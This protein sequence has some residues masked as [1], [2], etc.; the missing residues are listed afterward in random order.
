M[1][2]ALALTAF[3]RPQYLQQVLESLRRTGASDYTMFIGVEPVSSEVIKVCRSIDFLPTEITIN[4]KI[5]GVRENPF[6]TI[7]RAF[8]AGYDAVWQL[9]DDVVLSPDAANLVGA[10]LEFDR[11]DDFLCLNLYNSDSKVD[12]EH[13]IIASKGFNALSLAVTRTQWENYFVPNYWIHPSG[14]DWALTEFQKKANV[15]NLTPAMSRSHHIGREGGT[16]YRAAQ[17]DEMYIHNK[18]KKEGKVTEFKFLV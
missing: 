4:S 1:K 5:L 2:K 3:K 15:S 12:D 10:Y 11:K 8:D 16:H 18:W 7:K 9:E 14:W 13:N 17:H 6:Q